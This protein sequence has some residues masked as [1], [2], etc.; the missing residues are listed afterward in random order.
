MLR[1]TFI[2]L[3]GRAREVSASAGQSVMSAAVAA[4]IDEIAAECG[5]S[6]ACGT[7][8]CHIDPAWVDS[9]PAPQESERDMLEFVNNPSDT[10]RLSCQIRMAEALDGLVIHLPLSQY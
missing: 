5:G 4:G 1:I 6:G 3:G 7:C 8:H 9:L 10:S 2:D